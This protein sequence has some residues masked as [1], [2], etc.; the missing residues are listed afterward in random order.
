MGPGTTRV[1]LGDLISWR[2]DCVCTLNCVG[3]MMCKVPYSSCKVVTAHRESPSANCATSYYVVPYKNF[4]P[5]SAYYN[6][7]DEEDHEE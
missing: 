2:C 1:G 4:I 7:E 5:T 6:E 3:T